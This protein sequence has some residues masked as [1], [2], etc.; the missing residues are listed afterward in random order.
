MKRAAHDFCRQAQ[1]LNQLAIHRVH[2]KLL[3][4]HAIAQHGGFADF[5]VAIRVVPRLGKGLGFFAVYM[6]WGG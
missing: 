6:P 4:A 5:A 1:L 3:I 2:S